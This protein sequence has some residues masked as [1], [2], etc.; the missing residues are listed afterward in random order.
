MTVRPVLVQD[1]QIECCG[2]SFSVGDQVAWTL[3]LTP[4]GDWPEEMQVALNP[5]GQ[6]DDAQ[7][8]DLTI[9]RTSGAEVAVPRAAAGDGRAAIA[10]VLI[11]DHHGGVPAGL[12]ATR[13]TVRRIRVVSRQLRSAG[14]RAWE[15]V[16]GAVRL[17][18]VD[19]VPNLFADD[20]RED[21][22]RPPFWAEHGVVVNLESVGSTRLPTETSVSARPDIPPPRWLGR[23]RALPLVPRPYPT[24]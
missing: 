13:G 1:W 6:P 2:E 8:Q 4:A 15:S 14:E 3:L 24:R 21:R 23:L 10:G 11:E 9:V 22:P 18:E 12:S 19:R 5:A 20:R 17:R 7:E 16:E